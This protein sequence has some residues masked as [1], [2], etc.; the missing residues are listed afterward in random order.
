MKTSTK[1]ASMLLI[2]ALTTTSFVFAN[3]ASEKKENSTQNISFMWWGNETRNTATTNAGTDFMA[4]NPEVNISFMPNPYIGYHDKILLQLANG[5][6]PD[7]FCFSTQWMNEVGLEKNPALLDLTTIKDQLDVSGVDSKLLAGGKGRGKLLGVATGISGWNYSYFENAINSYVAKTGDELPPSIGGEWS[8]EEFI[9]YGER[10]HNTM[11]E[12]S[13]FVAFGDDI[14]ALFITILSEIANNFY[15]DA[16][17]NLMF[18]EADLLK[19]CD[20]FIEMTDKGV[21]PSPTLQ[22]EFMSGPSSLA[23]MMQD[24]KIGSI[25]Q[26]TSNNAQFEAQSKSKLVTLA[27]PSLGRSQCDG[28]FVRPSQFWVINASTKNP[29]VAVS[30]LNYILNDPKAIKDLGLERSVPPTTV[31]RQTLKGEGL[32]VGNAYDSTNYLIENADATYN[33]FIMVPEVMSTIK[34]AYTNMILGK[35]SDTDTANL[36]YTNISS[37]MGEIKSNYDL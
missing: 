11:G 14:G 1:L 27:Y 25:H 12:D 13:F 17:G 26:W 15:I 7:L 32:L 30:L 36:M 29:E 31:G 8:M 5:T 35:V 10:F 34:N 18:S 3:G 37:I 6:A 23:E 33:W 22:V 9:A 4:T 21:L 19:T 24:N 16:E 2:L 20:L 28:V